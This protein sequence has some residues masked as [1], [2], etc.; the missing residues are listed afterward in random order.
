MLSWLVFILQ[1][2]YTNFLSSDLMRVFLYTVELEVLDSVVSNFHEN[3]RYKRLS[4]CFNYTA[5]VAFSLIQLEAYQ[6]RNHHRNAA[7]F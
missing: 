6:C 4:S 1:V 7:I 3:P 5:V 2:E